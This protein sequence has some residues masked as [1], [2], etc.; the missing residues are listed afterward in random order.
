[1]SL[2]FDYASA[3]PVDPRVVEAMMPYLTDCF[4]NP[5]S[6]Y[7]QGRD[8]REAVELARS[9]VATAIGADPKEIVFTSGGTEA[10]NLAILGVAE[11]RVGY[12][13]KIVT[14]TIE[15]QAVLQPCQSL[16]EKGWQIEYLPV[17]D[18]GLVRDTTL[19]KSAG[20]FSLC[21]VMLANNE[22]GTV[23]PIQDLFHLAH[24]RG[25]YT[26]TDACQALGY[27]P[28]NVHAMEID[29]LSLN[30][31]KVYGPK[32][33]GALYIKRGIEIAPMQYGGKQELGRRAGTEN[34]PAIVGFGLACEIAVDQLGQEVA[35]LKVMQDYLFN[36][37]VKLGGI[38]NGDTENR[39]PN[40]VNVSFEG[41][42]P[43]AL[44]FYL[45]RCGI[46]VSSG[47][48]CSQ[49][50]M[51]ASHVL[52]ALGRNDNLAQSS[53]RISLG[54]QTTQSDC[55]VL[56]SELATILHN[57]KPYKKQP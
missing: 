28:I 37:L 44:L 6:L 10:N 12:S 55:D 31:G 42:E 51:V 11:A 13:K 8:A 16:H 3:T 36:A 19:L 24:K 14:T 34:V 1:M 45:D 15:H 4:A 41:I 48:A 17:T 25:A 57:L 20:N 46:M 2:Y 54:R 50:T 53:L 23:Q 56:L 40:N 5:S 35:R 7:R 43:E 21:S 27:I 18:N 52:R 30:S 47:S 33:C 26:H 29:L 38:I 22:I 49:S 32:G 9:R 39:L